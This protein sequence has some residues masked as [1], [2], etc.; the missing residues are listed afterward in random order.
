MNGKIITFNYN[1]TRRDGCLGHVILKGKVYDTILINGNT[2][3]LVMTE[4][5]FDHVLTFIVNPA[6]IDSIFVSIE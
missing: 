6:D 5:P 4:T 3:Y 1:Y 2:N